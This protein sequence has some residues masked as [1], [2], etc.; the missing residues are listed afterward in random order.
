MSKLPF[1][2]QP[3]LKPI[4]ERIGT[5]ETGIL[6]IER[7]GYLSAGEKAFLQQSQTG[8]DVSVKMLALVR[9]VSKDIK[10]SLE[11]AHQGVMNVLSGKVDGPNDAKI[12]SKYSTE[13]EHIMTL[14][15][16]TESRRILSQAACMLMYRVDPDLEIEEIMQLHPDLLQALAE[17]CLDEESKS[18]ERLQDTFK[19]Q[20]EEAVD[21]DSYEALEK[22]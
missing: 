17:L 4:I 12:A 11:A 21:A 1:V 14:A 3:R 6:E 20:E 16:S 7:R 13:I 18:T 10:I 15:M 2:V 8:D 9:K 22:K 19:N 5:E